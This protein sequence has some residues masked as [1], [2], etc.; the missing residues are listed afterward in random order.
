MTMRDCG[1]CT[2]ASPQRIDISYKPFSPLGRRGVTRTQTPDPTSTLFLT[3]GTTLAGDETGHP[4]RYYYHY[5]FFW[6]PQGRKKPRIRLMSQTRSAQSWQ[7]TTGKRAVDPSP[8][9]SL[10]SHFERGRASLLEERKFII[11]VGE[12]HALARGMST[13]RSRSAFA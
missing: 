8:F 11:F 12:R 1:D 2:Y 7:G 10:A 3:L 6:S 5:F 4:R 9:P 13:D